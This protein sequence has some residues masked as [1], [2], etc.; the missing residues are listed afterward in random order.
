LVLLVVASAV[1]IATFFRGGGATTTSQQVAVS[2]DSLRLYMREGAPART[3]R[4]VFDVVK[5]QQGVASVRLVSKEEAL[6]RLRH[7]YPTLANNLQSNPFPDS[8]TVRTRS[9]AGARRLAVT[10]RAKH[11]PGVA[12]VRVSQTR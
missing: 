8:L 4:T 12:V 5:A 6:A 9:A 11:L 2:A 10:L 1:M 7:R 3:L